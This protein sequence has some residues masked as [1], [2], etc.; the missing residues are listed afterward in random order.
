MTT[1][2]SMEFITLGIFALVVILGVINKIR[3]DSYVLKILPVDF[4]YFLI[5]QLYFVIFVLVVNIGDVFGAMIMSI[6]FVYL[7]V[8]SLISVYSFIV[9][10]DGMSSISFVIFVVVLIAYLF[11]SFYSVTSEMLLL[12]PLRLI[13]IFY[14]FYFL[15]DCLMRNYKINESIDF[16]ILGISLVVVSI[17]IYMSVLCA[18]DEPLYKP[19]GTFGIEF[20][21]YMFQKHLHSHQSTK[22]KTVQNLLKPI[23]KK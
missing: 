23:Y 4:A 19:L 14:V 22:L 20:V 17:I 8:M 15:D 2:G 10:I 11:F 6:L 21:A 12:Y 1:W 9:L 3:I 7:L 5:I 18:P 13:L 16:K